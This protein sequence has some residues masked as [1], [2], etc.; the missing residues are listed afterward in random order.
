MV[1]R[2]KL[3]LVGHDQ[4]FY[5]GGATLN[6]GKPIKTIRCRVQVYV[7]SLGAWAYQFDG[8]DEDMRKRTGL[9]KADNLFYD[10]KTLHKRYNE[11]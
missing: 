4:P 11:K 9:E 2:D 1:G 10:K 8:I 6:Y 7:H 3:I 5:K